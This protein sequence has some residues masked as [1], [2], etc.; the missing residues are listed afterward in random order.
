MLK[1]WRDGVPAQ[2]LKVKA[3]ASGDG[4][5][6][7]H[8][9]MNIKSLLNESQSK[10]CHAPSPMLGGSEKALPKNA[11]VRLSPNLQWNQ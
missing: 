8:L 10:H 5:L 4:G 1:R 11:K 3:K 2:P 6:N 9:V 7:T